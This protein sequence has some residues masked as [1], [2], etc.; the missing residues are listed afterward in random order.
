MASSSP[1]CPAS[2]ADGAQARSPVPPNIDC[3]IRYFYDAGGGKLGRFV[4]P[5]ALA[6]GGGGT[7]GGAASGFLTTVGVQARISPVPGAGGLAP[8]WD[9][10]EG[11]AYM[12]PNGL[13]S[14]SVPGATGPVSL[15]GGL[16]GVEYFTTSASSAVRF[17][18]GSPAFA[19]GFLAVAGASGPSG[20]QGPTAAPALTAACPLAG[21]PVTTAWMY[22]AAPAEGPEPPA[23]GYYSQPHSAGWFAPADQFL[24]PA[25]L[26]MANLVAEA[27]GPDG[28]GGYPMALYGA[29][30][31]PADDPALL[32]RFEAEILAPARL[33][34]IWNLAWPSAPTGSGPTGASG[35]TGPSLV[36]PQG[37][38]LWVDGQSWQWLVLASSAGRSLALADLD[39]RLAAAFQA[40]QMFLVVDKNGFAEL[41]ALCEPQFEALGIG[42][43]TFRLDQWDPGTLMIVKFAKA[44]LPALAGD[45][46]KWTLPGLVGTDVGAAQAAMTSAMAKAVQG[47]ASGDSD[48]DYFVDT[49]MADWNGILFLNV[50]VPPS[51]FPDQLMALTA[52]MTGPLEAHHIGVDLSPVTLGPGPSGPVPTVQDAKIFGLIVH[53]DDTDLTYHG[54][55]YDFKTLS[56]KVLFANS[57]VA[58]F[59]S[60]IELLVGALFG[61]RSTLVGG[62]HG[63]NIL[64]TGTL[65]KHDGADVYSFAQ[66]GPNGFAI[67]SAVLQSVQVT[68][69]EMITIAGAGGPSGPGSLA[70]ASGP[71]GASGPTGAVYTALFPLAGTVA[72]QEQPGF[73]LFS[74]G[75]T[76]MTGPIG[77]TAPSP[78]M[79]A[80]L[81]FKNLLVSMTFT[82]GDS[83]LADRVFAFDATQASLDL[84]SSRAR[85]G[86]LY[87]GFPL[88]AKG[89]L[90]GGPMP[91]T[92]GYLPLATPP[93]STG[94]LGSTWF[95]VAM[96]LALGTRGGL[97]GMAPL[98]ASLLTAWAPGSASAPANLAT[99]AMLPG[100][101]GIKSLGL[102][103]PLKLQLGDSSIDWSP[104]AAGNPA[105]VMRFN[106]IALSV[107][108]VKFPSGGRTNVAL[109]GDP[110][111]ARKSSSLGWYAAYLKNASAA[112]AANEEKRKS[113]PGKEI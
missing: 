97:A 6:S 52:G 48:Y 27:P 91:P 109:F 41:A 110:N 103:G 18:A 108:G 44:I 83:N 38:Q 24:T 1:L 57:A 112:A 28:P 88:T 69:A 2:G 13:W 11:R 101:R 7:D 46:S 45:P 25:P 31:G 76:G 111:P 17:V 89:F 85:P 84:S 26:R 22:L 72:F 12:T 23:Y 59:S 93:L 10:V 36:T 104:D 71:I 14:V 3:S 96:D 102:Q 68:S 51:A 105:Y 73:D 94:S 65:Q 43:W 64:L 37:L 113:T 58:G 74:F 56:L 98:T 87:D 63:D 30:P 39:P 86:S 53:E 20:M 29:G 8:Q 55:A 50:P 79:G 47:K 5:V 70:R 60:R 78:D 15:L 62:L 32:A 67:A 35:P 54:S 92:L 106:D 16:S 99:L 19:P 82:E 80:G 75:S 81:R 40:E 42:G 107:F 61:E 95:G 34:A 77:P 33:D 66:S 49:V 21:Q 4:Y 90:Q 100:T 9:P